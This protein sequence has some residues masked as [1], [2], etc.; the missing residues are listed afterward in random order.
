MK[1]TH[2]YSY[3]G[4][5]ITKKGSKEA[6]SKIV[7]FGT[8]IGSNSAK[9]LVELNTRPNKNWTLVELWHAMS[10]FKLE[11]ETDAP[12]IWKILRDLERDGFIKIASPI[13]SAAPFIDIHKDTEV[14]FEP[15][16]K[17]SKMRV[18]RV[19]SQPKLGKLSRRGYSDKEGS[20]L[21][22]RHHK[23]FRKL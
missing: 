1:S 19:P 6:K 7:R 18:E 20:R 12:D 22:R 21:S 16:P 15:I 14:T 9:A 2:P 11:R 13:K 5:K 3:P 10:G 4:I 8:L 23:G 17:T